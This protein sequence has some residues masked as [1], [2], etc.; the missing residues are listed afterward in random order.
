EKSTLD[1]NRYGIQPR[2]MK[3][4]SASSGV[5]VERMDASPPAPVA[6]PVARVSESAYVAPAPVQAVPV[7]A[8]PP[9]VQTPIFSPKTGTISMEL[10]ADDFDLTCEACQ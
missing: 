1:V 4:R 7:V 10:D 6:Q 2:W 5:Q 9:V 8:P 3:A